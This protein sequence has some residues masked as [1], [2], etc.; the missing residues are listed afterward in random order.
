MTHTGAVEVQ[1]YG[2]GGGGVCEHHRECMR[3]KMHLIYEDT[4]E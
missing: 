2:G 3:E 4:A 1:R